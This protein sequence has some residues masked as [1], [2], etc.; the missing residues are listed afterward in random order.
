MMRCNDVVFATPSNFLLQLYGNVRATLDSNSL[1][2]FS[3]Q[4]IIILGTSFQEEYFIK[5]ILYS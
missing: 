4:A 5:V 1:N 3:K 2:F